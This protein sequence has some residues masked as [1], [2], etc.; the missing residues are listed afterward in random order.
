M[1]KIFYIL[2]STLLFSMLY[3]PSAS[4]QSKAKSKKKRTANA[5]KESDKIDIDS[6]LNT[7]RFEEAIQAIEEE[8]AIL[9]KKKKD[10]DLSALEK[11]TAYARTAQ[12]MLLGTERVAFI[13][14]IVVGKSDLLSAFHLAAENGRI[15]SAEKLLGPTGVNSSLAG[16][17]AFKN[18]LGDKI[19]ISTLNADSVLRI[20]ESNKYGHEWI[21][22]NMKGVTDRNEEQDYPFMMADG[23]TLYYAAKGRES[24]G[25]YDIFV[26]RFNSESKQYVHP[27][28]IGMPFNSP[29]NDYLFVIDET[30]Q[31]GW[32]A[33]DRYQPAD[34][35]CIYTFVPSESRKIYTLTPANAERVRTAAMILPLSNSLADSTQMAEAKK[36]L[37]LLLRE[38]S[39]KEMGI[40]TRYII[41]DQ[42]VY[43]SPSEFRS[44]AARRI[45]LQLDK[46]LADMKKKQTELEKLRK[47]YPSTSDKTTAAQQILALEKDVEQLRISIL[48]L[49][50]NMRKAETQ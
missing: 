7:Y 19:L 34:S 16:K 48:T 40:S 49:E 20:V 35:V 29:A 39:Q 2:C 33:S 18:E 27:E 23:I 21:T 10:A 26:T 41:N 25:G 45:A 6:L 5:A 3:I 9:L 15:E 13:D 14:S 1:S 43:T 31:I 37:A 32:F 8:K 42:L 22:E 36:R 4:A 38:E 28:N 47:Q 30:H 44:E 46:T 11:K 17:T 50:K 24:L 12:N